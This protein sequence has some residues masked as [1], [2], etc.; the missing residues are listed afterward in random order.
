MAESSVI[1]EF[2]VAIGFKSDEAA[3]KKFSNGIEAATKVVT[4]LAVAVESAATTINI[5]VSR[6]ASNLEALYFASLR[7]G[8]SAVNLKALDRAAQNFGLS[9]G[10][11]VQTV[12]NL[13]SFLRKNPASEGFIA[14]LG[15]HTRDANHNLRDTTD[16]LLDIGKALSTKSFPVANLWASRFGIS[17]KMLLAMRNGEF[18]AYVASQRQALHDSGYDEAARAAH[19]YEEAMRRLETRFDAIRVKVGRGLLRGLQPELDKIADWFDQHGDEIAGWAETFAKGVETGGKLILPIL[20]KIAEG[21]KNIY[22]WTK[23]AG[24][25]AVEHLPQSMVDRIGKSVGWVFDKLG[26]KGEVDKLL[27]LESAGITPTREFAGDT[28]GFRNHNPGNLRYAGQAGATNAGGFAKFTRDD[29]GLLAMANQLE[30]YARRQ[31]NTIN[32]I[33]RVYAPKSDG[34][35]TG[36]YITDVSKT[37]GIGATQRLDLDNPK[38][39]AALM[40]AMVKHEQGSMPY[41]SGMIQSIANTALQRGPVTLTVSPVTTINVTGENPTAIAKDVAASQTR[42]TADVTRNSLAVIQ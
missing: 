3:L 4:A 15:V 38:V 11:A 36:A 26:I 22:D 1:K 42:V 27:D 12:E 7:T 24:E 8:A 13:A 5:G 33:V 18:E 35:D 28:V 23:A 2:L 29:Q 25:A 10:E 9:A 19:E 39:L 17:E 14:G 31:I 16:I 34:N 6:F 30:R 41:S 32:D 21:W 37:M 40:N 20:G